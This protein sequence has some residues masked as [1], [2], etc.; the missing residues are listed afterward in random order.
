MVCV[1]GHMCVYRGQRLTLCFLVCYFFFLH[2]FFWLTRPP[3]L[4]WAPQDKASFLTDSQSLPG[5]PCCYWHLLP[6]WVAPDTEF[7]P[8]QTLSSFSLQTKT[9]LWP[10][11]KPIS[12][13]SWLS[14]IPLLFLHAGTLAWV[15]YWPKA[16]E[17]P[18]DTTSLTELVP[19]EAKESSQVGGRM[20]SLP[21][22]YWAEKDTGYLSTFEKLFINTETWTSLL[23]GQ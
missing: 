11:G 8:P 5:T 1:Y 22:P 20:M 6:Q 4:C 14:H 7:P 3:Q 16:S 15:G 21:F 18:T 19:R 13:I 9:E 2:S 23:Y 12:F 10:F 17:W